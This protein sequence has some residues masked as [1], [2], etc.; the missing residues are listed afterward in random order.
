MCMAAEKQLESWQPRVW[1][2]RT[3]P[4][5]RRIVW[6]MVPDAGNRR[7]LLERGDAALANRFLNLF[8]RI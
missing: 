1:K 5:I 7:A 8:F 6:R 2:F 3:L 4:K